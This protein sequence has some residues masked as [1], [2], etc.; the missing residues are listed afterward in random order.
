MKKIKMF[1][2][3]CICVVAVLQCGTEAKAT[4][5][6]KVNTSVQISTQERK[7]QFT[8]EK[9]GKIELSATPVNG[10]RV[11]GCLVLY[12][13]DEDGNEIQIVSDGNIH[14]DYG[15]T[16]LNTTPVR[17]PAGTYIIGYYISSP[18]LQQTQA[19]LTI[20]YTEENAN[21]YESEK[22]NTW[23]TANTIELNKEY[24][25]NLQSYNDEDIYQFNLEQEGSLYVNLRNAERFVDMWKV[26]L[27]AEDEY[28]NHNLINSWSNTANTN[29]KFTRYRLP[30]GKYYIQVSGGSRFGD[31]YNYSMIDSIDYT[32]GTT[33]VAETNADSEIEYN[34]L[35][36]TA[37]QINTNTEY[38]ANI[39]TIQDVDYFMFTM[40][41]ASK[42][43]IQ[44]RQEVDTVIAG[45][46]NVTLY[47]KDGNGNLVMYDRF[48]TTSNKVSWGNEVTTPEGTYIIC[49]KNNT[50]WAEDK[51]DYI[52]KVIQ[53]PIITTMDSSNVQLSKTSF[54]YNGKAQKPTITVIDNG[55]NI[56]DTTN[57][58]ISY[59]NNKNV[60]QASVTVTFVGNYS[61]TVRKTFNIVPKGT[62][63][64][65][66]TAQKKGFTVKWKKQTK[67][68]TGYEIQYS[69]NSKFKGAKTVK[70][71]KAKTTTKRISKLKAKKKYYVK[72]RTYKTVK[73]RKYYSDWSKSK[74]VVTKK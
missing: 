62:S 7:Y 42:V 66:V 64:S 24:T 48:I 58:T 63:L 19:K 31:E 54:I 47:Q 71:I 46:Y 56:V 20:Q 25:A 10:S 33:Y 26:A 44:M 36:D 35:I 65:K 73:G 43:T 32:I 13:I 37:N 49:V 39:A 12:E 15:Y 27:Y 11:T 50:G 52:L 5:E 23:S 57:Y 16:S 17:L 21:E 68:I 4:Q 41:K 9:Q 38:K 29:S 72:I 67:Q 74:K 45:L 8:I 40:E 3:M 59:S 14:N 51:N 28:G 6:L 1:L 60:G 2:G 22:N 18:P 69:T 34:D 30:K 55:G 53:S 70:N 61:G